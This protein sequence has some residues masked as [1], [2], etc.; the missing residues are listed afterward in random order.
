MPF[1]D[2]S[3]S[4]PDA[5][6]NI[7][8]DTL[9]RGKQALVFCNTK[10]GAESQAEK[11]AQKVKTVA[12]EEEL[13][14]IAQQILDAV[15]SP[16]KQC[17]RLAACVKKGISF[18]HSGL[19]A[20]QREI[21][22]TRFR[23]GIIKIICATPTL[24]MGM[25]L[26][27]FR[28][29]IRDLKRYTQGTSWGMADIP[30]LEYEQMSGRAGRPGK[31]DFGE[32]ICVAQ[33]ESE[34]EKIVERYIYGDPE[35]IY[36]KLAVEPVLRT[37]VLSL[38][39]SGYVHDTN[40]LYDFFDETFYA[41]QYEDTDKLHAILDKMVALLA[42]WAFIKPIAAQDEFLPADAI[43]DGKL[44]A[45]PLGERVAQLYLDPLT[46]HHVL[47]SIENGI[48]SNLRLTEFPL[49]HMLCTTLEMRPWFSVR[50]GEFDLIDR[51]L[52][53]HETN[54]FVK[55]PSLYSH[56]YE[57]FLQTIKTAVVL[58]DWVAE[59]G[60]DVLLAEHNVRPGELQAKLA[61]ADWLLYSLVE[62]SKIKKWHSL[63]ADFEKMRVR[64]E[65]G[66][67]EEI[68]PL[69]RLKGIGRV[70][71]RKLYHN[72][73]RSIDAI[74]QAEL[75]TL[76]SLVGEAVAASIKEQIGQKVDPEE[77]SVKRNKRK[78]QINLGDYKE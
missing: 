22:E 64:L 25:D 60:E 68:L 72:G 36:S 56:D 66:A 65:Y 73:I 15:Q 67:K 8:I 41:F 77:L 37:Y 11:I 75:S 34:K 12:D 70:R 5:T 23:E 63:I 61:R 2:I 21:I 42:K 3:E 44:E 17:Q 57:E 48:A 43:V 52:L 47:T 50:Q 55:A 49:L 40:S 6:L 53:E 27:A 10:R 76:K 59:T 19:H 58:Q 9:Q 26:P 38:I 16:T 74:R 39:A 14:K 1:T 28:S 29:I 7:A 45:T 71:A 32:A 30:V 46:A 24:A 35:S 62:L 31:E 51:K 54:L 69:L 4:Y 78:G 13:Q 33:T 20:K 18:H